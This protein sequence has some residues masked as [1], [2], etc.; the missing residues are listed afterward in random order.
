VAGYFHIGEQDRREVKRRRRRRRRRLR[1]E[2][3]GQNPMPRSNP[4]NINN[5]VRLKN[6]FCPKPKLACRTTR[7]LSRSREFTRTPRMVRRQGDKDE[8]DL[9]IECFRD[10]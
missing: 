7:P 3:I 10:L 8:I 2:P 9:L 1:V 6:P 4:I 5:Q